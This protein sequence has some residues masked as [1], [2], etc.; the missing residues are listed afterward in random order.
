ML[1]LK[2]QLIHLAILLL[3][4]LGGFAVSFHFYIKFFKVLCFTKLTFDQLVLFNPYRW[5]L[6]VIRVLTGFYFKIWHNLLP[7]V[8]LGTGSMDLSILMGLEFLNNMVFV[9][10]MISKNLLVF[11][12]QNLS[13]LINL[14]HAISIGS[15]ISNI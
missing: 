4:I 1:Y 9:S 2:I 8:R 12:G 6:S 3:K 5:P 15:K 7:P 13:Y 11:V 10:E 14:E